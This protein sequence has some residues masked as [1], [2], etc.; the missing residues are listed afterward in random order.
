MNY[1]ALRQVP[2]RPSGT[3]R[4]LW[5]FVILQ[6][7]GLTL[8]WVRSPN[9]KLSSSL[10]I[11]SENVAERVFED[12]PN[13]SRFPVEEEDLPCIGEKCQALGENLSVEAF[14]RLFRIEDEKGN[15]E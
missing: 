6:R 1:V 12:A 10:V 2:Y 11:A 15:N 5:A 3:S 4:L 13:V 8:L 7:E 14:R 9:L